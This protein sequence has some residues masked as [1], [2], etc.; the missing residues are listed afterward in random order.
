MRKLKIIVLVLGLILVGQ[1]KAEDITLKY[2]KRSSQDNP[3][4]SNRGNAP[5]HLPI[6]VDFD[7]A[8]GLLMVSAPEDMEGVVYVYTEDGRLEASSNRLNFTLQL[9]SK[10]LHF[11]SIQG[12]N[13]IGE[14]KFVF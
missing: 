10:G 11:L 9:S 6:K 7:N 8:S 2:K 12:D 1:T 4:I 5:M 3:P 14:A 13:W